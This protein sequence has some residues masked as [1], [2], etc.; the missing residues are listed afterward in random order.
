MW[1][2]F[3]HACL[4]YRGALPTHALPLHT[5]VSVSYLEVLVSGELLVL[6]YALPNTTK[7]QTPESPCLI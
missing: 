5:Q 2:W 4:A 6:V 7:L 3:Y 1:V